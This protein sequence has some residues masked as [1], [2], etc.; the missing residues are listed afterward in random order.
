MSS[1]VNSPDFEPTNPKSWWC[2]VAEVLNP[3]VIGFPPTFHRYRPTKNDW[4]VPS[5]RCTRCGKKV[6]YNNRG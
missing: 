1:D 4:D 5:Y 6:S 3:D 2:R